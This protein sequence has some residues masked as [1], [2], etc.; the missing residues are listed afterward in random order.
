M[1]QCTEH[2]TARLCNLCTRAAK[3]AARLQPRAPWPGVNFAVHKRVRAA[4]TRDLPGVL[5]RAAEYSL[6]SGEEV[7][8][9][10]VPAFE[11]RYTSGCLVACTSTGKALSR[12]EQGSYIYVRSPVH[13]HM[14]TVS[15]IRHEESGV[16]RKYSREAWSGPPDPDRDVQTLQSRL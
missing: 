5:H 16:A 7:E 11:Y 6:A 2:C 10:G 9:H 4:L 14:P 1:H 15:H 8:R 13:L 3:R 12:S